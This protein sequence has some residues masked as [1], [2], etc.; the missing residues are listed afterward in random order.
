MNNKE[1]V[2]AT[3]KKSSKHLTAYDILDKIQKTRKIQ[4]MTIYRA[5]D[6]L[7]KEDRIHKS[8]QNKTFILCKHSHKENH[9]TAIAVC[10]KCGDS[11]EIKTV[12]LTNLLKKS[13]NQ[14]YDFNNFSLEVLTQ[15]K[16]CK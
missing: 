11:D 2:F 9:N 15:C 4:P 12:F 7:M 13:S 5:L 16:G 3:I 10:K 8:N 14:K 1:L 6:S